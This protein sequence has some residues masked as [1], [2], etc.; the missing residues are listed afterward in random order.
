LGKGYLRNK[1]GSE[2]SKGSKGSEGCGGALQAHYKRGCEKM[3]NLLSDSQTIQRQTP[4][5]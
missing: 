3:V 4:Y 1:K 5:L 2:G